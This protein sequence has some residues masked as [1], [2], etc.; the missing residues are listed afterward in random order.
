MRHVEME[1][2]LE[3]KPVM[4]EIH[5]IMMVVHQHVLRKLVIDVMEDLHFVGLYVEMG[6][7]PATSNVMI[8]IKKV[9]TVV[10]LTVRSNLDRSVEGNHQSA[11]I[12]IIYS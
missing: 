7:L 12:E 9:V 5:I 3:D 6:L 4:M 10:L 11:G 1:E 2:L 8:E